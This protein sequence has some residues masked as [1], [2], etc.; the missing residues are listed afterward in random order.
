MCYLAATSLLLLAGHNRVGLVG[1]ALHLLLLAAVA[2]ATLPR[3]APAWLRSWAPLLA[4]LFLYSEVPLLIQA[5]GHDRFFDMTVISW[6]TAAFSGQP[7][8]EWAVRW[9]S[10]WL[11]ELLHAAYLAYYPIIFSVPA[12]LWVWKRHEFPEAAFVLL[13]T[14]IACFVFYILFPVEGPRYLWPGSQ[15]NGTLRAFT[16]WLLEA[17]SSRGTAFPS[18]HVAVAT[19]QAVLAWHYFGWR[20]GVT[21]G[22]VTA[23]LAAG[24]VYG[25]FHYLVDVLA[26]GVFGL[27]VS[28][29]GLEVFAALERIFGQANATAPT[30][31]ADSRSGSESSTSSSGAAS[32]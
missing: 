9:P 21:L 25:G 28:L 5:A 2:L 3:R 14:F 24:A 7:A 27:L 31:P 12:A 22:V 29:T 19:A 8:I 32:T 6:E 13:L 1:I 16:V 17:R 23:A 10:R 30:N 15:E 11:S 26:G 20:A 18:S 4:L